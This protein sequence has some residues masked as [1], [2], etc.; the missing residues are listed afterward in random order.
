R[1]V[2][3]RRC[4]RGPVLDG[5]LVGGRRAGPP[6]PVRPGHG[7]DPIPV[8]PHRPPAAVEL[9]RMEPF[10]F[11]ARDG[12]ELHGYLSFPPGRGRVA[13]PAVASVH[14]GPWTRDHRGLDP[15]TQVPAT[16]RYLR[17]PGPPR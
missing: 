16:R 8:P 11:L 13:L 6:S 10:Q 14:G 15:L 12:L 5:G 9:A 2:R 3:R 7:R 1:P 17:L 4:P